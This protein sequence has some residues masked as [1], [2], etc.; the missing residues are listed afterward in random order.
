MF[1][2]KVNFHQQIFAALI[3]YW[4]KTKGHRSSGLLFTFFLLLTLFSIPQLRWEINN[5]NSSHFGNDGITWEGYQFIIYITFFTL[6]SCMLV[7]NCFA[8]KAPRHTTYPKSSKPS[9]ELGCSV[10]SRIFFAWF[11]K[12]TWTGW[13]NPLLES[14]IFDI[15]PE[16]ASNEMVPIFDKNF[17]R[18]L[19]S[20]KRYESD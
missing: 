18:S 6:I 17:Q 8:D 19:D 13:K 16:N 15:N 4:H 14:S 9:P 11:D 20:Q 12:T 1:V 7:L 10:L 5:Y 2:I 3:Q